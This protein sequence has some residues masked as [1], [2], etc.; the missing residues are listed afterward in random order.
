MCLPLV[1]LDPVRLPV[2]LG[3]VWSRRVGSCQRLHVRIAHPANVAEHLLRVLPEIGRRAH[4]RRRGAGVPRHDAHGFEAAVLILDLRDIVVGQHLGVRGY[5]LIVQDRSYG[6]AHFDNPLDPVVAGLF[7]QAGL[8]ALTEVAGV[9]PAPAL[10]LCALVCHELLKPERL[11][12]L[13]PEVIFHAG[14]ACEPLPIA[15]RVVREVDVV[16]V[17]WA[18]VVSLVARE[19]RGHARDGLELKHGAQLRALELLAHA[20]LLASIQRRSYVEGKVKGPHLVGRAPL[21][22][23]RHMR[24]TTPLGHGSTAHALAHDVEGAPERPGTLGAEARVRAV[25]EPRVYSL[26]VLVPKPQAVQHSNL[27][28]LN[29]DVGPLDKAFQRR[30]G[31]RALEVELDRA[32]AAVEGLVVAAEPAVVADEAPACVTQT[33][34]LDLD[35]VRSDVC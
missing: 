17:G 12:E 33:R 32:L 4:W 8:D 21:R 25:D 16:R 10:V 29:E 14:C 35:D 31:R 19:E 6:H 23:P 24:W 5:L 26:A 1:N 27:V 28:V 30:P 13:R 2:T 20:R 7:L 3:A 11:A 15:A 9:L 34:L 22:E 18:A